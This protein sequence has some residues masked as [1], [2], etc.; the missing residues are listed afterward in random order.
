MKLYIITKDGLPYNGSKQKEET[1]VK[2]YYDRKLAEKTAKGFCTADAN[3][4][5]RYGDG[6]YQ[7][8]TLKQQERNELA[9]KLAKQELTRWSVIVVNF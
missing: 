5:Y 9:K 7:T 2:A 3:T 8:E 1:F 6:Y 4:Y